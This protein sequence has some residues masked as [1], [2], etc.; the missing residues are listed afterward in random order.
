MPERYKKY[1]MTT[2]KT[3]SGRKPD[4][5]RYFAPTKRN[6]THN[7]VPSESAGY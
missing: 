4:D 2:G 7:Q 1:K 5:A 6:R 3:I